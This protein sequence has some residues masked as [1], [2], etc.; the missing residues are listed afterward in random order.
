MTQKFE[1]TQQ[2]QEQQQQ[3]HKCRSGHNNK[4]Q[5]ATTT[6][7]SNNNKTEEEANKI[8]SLFALIVLGGCVPVCVYMCVSLYVS[9]CVPPCVCVSVWLPLLCVSL[10]VCVRVAQRK[11]FLQFQCQRALRHKAS[12][13]VERG[14]T[15]GVA[16]IAVT[17]R[18][19]RC[20]CACVYVCVTV[21]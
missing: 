9:T 18:P 11:L 1:L 6:T 19:V 3:Q 17:R 2:Q 15:G 7:S 14:E 4:Q 8:F 21:N 5:Q 13:K 10:S 16:G 12:R 20:T